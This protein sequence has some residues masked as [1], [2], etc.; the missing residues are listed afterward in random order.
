MRG[1]CANQCS[2]I[3]KLPDAS[4]HYAGIASV[5]AF[6]KFM[7]CIRRRSLIYEPDQSE[8]ERKE[9][10]TGLPLQP[11]ECGICIYLHRNRWINKILGITICCD[12]IL[13]RAQLNPKGITKYAGT[14]R[15]GYTPWGAVR[16]PGNAD[17]C[18][19]ADQGTPRRP[20]K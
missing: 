1:K 2:I 18:A 17:L 13:C 9:M 14:S 16:V 4:V 6:M 20:K 15:Q 5:D 12:F 3:D 11:V 7:R 10:E 19:D 8:R